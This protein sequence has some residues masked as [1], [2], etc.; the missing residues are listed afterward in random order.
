[1]ACNN[2]LVVMM[3]SRERIESAYLESREVSH[4]VEIRVLS[5]RKASRIRKS[6]DL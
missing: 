6:I 3:D 5:G 2:V 1:M 4:V